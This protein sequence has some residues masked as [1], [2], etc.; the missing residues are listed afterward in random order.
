MAT[1]AQFDARS[2]QLRAA[3]DGHPRLTGLVLLGSAAEEARPRRDE[4]S[5]HDFFAIIADGSGAL[6]RPDLSWLPGQA[7][8]AATAREGEIGF[9]ALYDDGHVFEFALAELGELDSAVAEEATVV[10][11]ADGRLTALVD[12]ARTRAQTR[13]R[14]DAAGEAT[15]VFV[16][17]LIGVG[18]AHRG[19]VLAAGEFVRTWA[20]QCLVR[21]VRARA[22]E[23]AGVAAGDAAPPIDPVRR[24]ER[25]HPV[26]AGRIAHALERPVADAA[27]ELYDIARQTL[28][29]GWEQFPT[30][31]ADAVALRLG[32]R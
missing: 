9:V 7:S 2:E 28:E 6:L 22:A 24:F 18:R 20:V 4:W 1:A 5:D 29:P 26:V 23:A 16:K 25:D 14:H 8:L 11:D 3:V 10:S 12:A 31:A 13:G 32:W 19:E 17:L 30:R 15:L 27:R 21:A